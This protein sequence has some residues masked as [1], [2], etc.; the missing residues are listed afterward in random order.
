MLCA[1]FV[2]QRCVNKLCV[3]KLCVGKLCVGKLCVGKLCVSKLCVSKLGKAGE[4]E[5]RT[6]GGSAQP[7]PRTP[8][9]DVGKKTCM[10]WK[11]FIS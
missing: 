6:A 4:E 2:V 11:S 9:N 3:S 1:S 5:G 10:T 7:K 8:H